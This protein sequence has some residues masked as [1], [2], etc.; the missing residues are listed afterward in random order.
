M[1]VTPSENRPAKGLVLFVHGLGGHATKTWGNF[2]SLIKND[3]ELGQKYAVAYYSFPTSVFG[4]PLFWRKFPKIQ[5]LAKGLR[6]DLDTRF[7]EYAEV[8]LVCHSLGGL[9]ARKYLIDELNTAQRALRVKKLLL[10]ATPNTGAELAGI[11]S[12]VP[13]GHT[14]ISQLCRNSDLIEFLNE[15]WF[16]LQ[17]DQKLD[18]KY[19]VGALDRV[20]E[21]SSAIGYWGNLTLETVVDKGHRALV[22]PQVCTDLSF[23]ILKK[24]LLAN[25]NIIARTPITDMQA[26]P[27]QSTDIEQERSLPASGLAENFLPA[28][29]PIIA[30]DSKEEQTPPFVSWILFSDRR[31]NHVEIVDRATDGTAAFKLSA[32]SNGYVGVNKVFRTLH[33]RV[34]FDYIIEDSASEGANMFFYMIPMEETGPERSGWIEV[35]TNLQAD[36]RSGFSRHRAAFVVPTKYYGDGQWH[37]GA[38]EFDF[39]ETRG[40]FFSIFG[41]RINEGANNRGAGTMLLANVKLL[42]YE[43][44]N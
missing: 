17:L 16:R 41:P 36:P 18:V 33:G 32:T 34:E 30:Y 38:L 23:L 26:R 8:N 4:F 27:R 19:V 21:A 43:L 28:R 6:T 24:F 39:R 14:Q 35:E 40:A 3:K 9:I 7:P 29:A 25:G 1:K 37:H 15:D 22:K 20:V 10:F 2:A 12:L 13:W 44:P 42:S 31:D 11:A 5:T